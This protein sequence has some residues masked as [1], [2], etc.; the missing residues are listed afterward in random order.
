MKNYNDLNSNLKQWIEEIASEDK[1]GLNPS[2]LYRNIYN[3]TGKY[4]QLADIFEVPIGLI[5]AIKEEN[6]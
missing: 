5:K 3:S 2:T 4:K 1:F 6:E